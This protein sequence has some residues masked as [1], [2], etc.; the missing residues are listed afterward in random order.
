[1]ERQSVVS[2]EVV[3]KMEFLSERLRAFVRQ[4]LTRAASKDALLVQGVLDELAAAGVEVLTG[5]V[6]QTAE[7]FRSAFEDTTGEVFTPSAFRAWRLGLLGRAHMMVIVRT[8]LSESGAFEIA[9]N[10]VVT[11]RPMFFAVHAG[12]PITTTLLRDLEPL[13]PT[14]YVTFE[15]PGE[16]AEPLAR[17]LAQAR[18]AS[19]VSTALLAARLEQLR[20]TLVTD[21]DTADPL[22]AAAASALV[23]AQELLGLVTVT[24]TSQHTSELHDA[25]QAARAL[26]GEVTYAVRAH[27]DSR[28]VIAAST[29]ISTARDSKMPM[30]VTNRN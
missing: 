12:M 21:L 13:C 11:R 25:L 24:N 20:L 4:P 29:Y 14:T 1:V 16:L 26:V 19:A 5:P 15:D 23:T 28:R 27:T 10:S 3:G 17:F 2:A 18:H 8:E 30:A 6:A 7:S 22:V 9:Y